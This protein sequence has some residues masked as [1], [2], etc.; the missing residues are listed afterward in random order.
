MKFLP[1]SRALMAGA[2]LIA[3]SLAGADV[4]YET[5]YLPTTSVVL[6]TSTVLSTSYVSPTSYTSYLTPTVST[7]YLTPT[8]TIV[9]P[10]DVLFPTSS[11]VSTYQTVRRPRRYVERTSY[12]VAPR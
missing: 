8:S 6:P 5:A 7:S 3:P 9:S 11:Y 4:I 10:D 1:M 2:L 12:Y